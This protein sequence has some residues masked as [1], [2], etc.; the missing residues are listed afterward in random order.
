MSR[1]ERTDE[2]LKKAADH[3]RY[4]IEMLGYTAKRLRPSKP[5]CPLARNA[6]I[7]S[8]GIH[9]RVIIDF[10]YRDESNAHPHDVLA[11]HFY[12]TPKEPKDKSKPQILGDLFPERVNAEI[13]HLS[14]KRLQ[15]TL[16][17]K[18]WPV[19][20][21]TAEIRSALLKFAEFASSEHVGADFREYTKK[22]I[23]VANGSDDYSA[24]TGYTGTSSHW[25]TPCRGL[26]KLDADQNAFTGDP[27]D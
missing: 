9:C 10:L 12:R 11:V 22:A 15:K 24:T 3:L 23:Q 21:I 25:V 1:T 18:G 6:L 16:D 17:E 5:E 2:E 20:K 14:Y 19:Q 26:D 27:D 4:E 8:F 13:A 7:E